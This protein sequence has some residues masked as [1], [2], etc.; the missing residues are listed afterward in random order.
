[1]EDEYVTDERELA[2]EFIR[3]NWPTLAAMAWRFHL[4]YGRGA[5]IVDWAVL[6]RWHDHRHELRVHP[7]YTAKPKDS[8]LES[9][10]SEYDPATSVV[11]AFSREAI[12]D[13]PAAGGLELFLAEPVELREGMAF[14]AMTVTAV[15]S[16]AEAHR[17][18]GH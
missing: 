6:T 5:L 9:M 17:A 18:S 8:E 11:I 14:A 4:H 12:D 13:A 2:L 15:P 16:P 7:H 10:I 1:M 3:A